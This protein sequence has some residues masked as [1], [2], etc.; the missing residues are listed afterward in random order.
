MVV[1]DAI[2]QNTVAI[3]IVTAFILTLLLPKLWKFLT[4]G[5]ILFALGL[6]PL[7]HMFNKISFNIV[8]IPVFQYLLM[9]IV[10]WDG[11]ELIV[12]GIKEE[13]EILKWASIGFGVILI[14][15]GTIP[16]L[17]KLG[18]ISFSLPQIPEVILYSIYMISGL[19]LAM[20]AFVFAHE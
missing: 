4:N 12:E 13:N 10:I 2:I 14:V 18:A 20:G 6:L 7:L 5:I 11:R 8:D 15:L 16:L 17:F 3:A 9:I 1:S 19:L